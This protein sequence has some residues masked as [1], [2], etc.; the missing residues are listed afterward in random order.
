MVPFSASW[1]STASG[2]PRLIVTR[3]ERGA[4]D[5]TIRQDT[6]P[7]PR[8]VCYAG[9]RTSCRGAIAGATDEMPNVPHIELDLAADYAI[10]KIK[11]SVIGV[12]GR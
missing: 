4:T 7:D 10:A 2:K 9:T 11:E 1:R 6:A 5:R 3:H 8:Q 12:T